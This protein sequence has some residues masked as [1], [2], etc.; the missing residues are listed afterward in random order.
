MTKQKFIFKSQNISIPVN[1]FE[2]N[3]K[4]NISYNLFNFFPIFGDVLDIQLEGKIILF[5]LIIF[6]FVNTCKEFLENKNN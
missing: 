2:N 1:V 3:S 6:L 5:Y 4:D